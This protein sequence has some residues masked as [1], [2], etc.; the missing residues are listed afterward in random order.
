MKKLAILIILFLS[1]TQ[2][3]EA[4][5]LQFNQAVFYTY[6]PGNADGNS[7][8]PS[9]TGQLVVNPNQ[10]LKI[11]YVYCSSQNASNGAS[12]YITYGYITIN[13]VL[14]EGESWLPSGT[15]TIKTYDTSLTGSFK[16]AISGI[17]YDIVP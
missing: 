9:F 11:T 12:S 7:T 3:I 15:Y 14:S 2:K 13:D 17:L 10:V 6:G 8:T 16:G 4:Q 1:L 5:N